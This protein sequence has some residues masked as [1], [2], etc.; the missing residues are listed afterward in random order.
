MIPSG[1]VKLPAD[2]VYT[3]GRG[4][5]VITGTPVASHNC[6]QMGCASAG[7]HVIAYGKLIVADCWPSPQRVMLDLRDTSD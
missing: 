7:P 3:D 4:R 2:E 6:D 5:I 1:F